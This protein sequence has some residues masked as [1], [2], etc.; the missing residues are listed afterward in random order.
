MT[1]GVARKTRSWRLSARA[2]ACVLGALVVALLSFVGTAGAAPVAAFEGP[3]RP[4]FDTRIVFGVA[5]E[6]DLPAVLA[7]AGE[8]GE[9][10][11]TS[12]SVVGV[13]TI[14]PTTVG[15][16]ELRAAL[17]RIDGV[18]WAEPERTV[19]ALAA[20]NDPRFWDQKALLT[21]QVARAW[22]TSPGSSSVIVGVV[23]SGVGQHPDLAGRLLPGYNLA[24]PEHPDDTSDG[25]G[26]G[27]CLLYT[28]DA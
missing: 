24:H 15:A 20:P 22:E 5:P 23:D 1:P 9:L 6:A 12:L 14:V 3:L 19:I 11:E 13:H 27:T 25:N 10:A 21:M 8:W 16:S 26:H 4:T 18:L 28:S 7:A 2:V 17:A